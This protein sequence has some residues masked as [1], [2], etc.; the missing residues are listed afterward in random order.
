MAE[1]TFTLLTP[2][3]LYSISKSSHQDIRTITVG[4]LQM[5]KLRKISKKVTAARKDWS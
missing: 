4:I 1:P 3:I 2:A 5:R